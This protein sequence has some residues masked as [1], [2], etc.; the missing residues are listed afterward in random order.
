MSHPI[1]PILEVVI[2]LATRLHQTATVLRL[3]ATLRRLRATLRQLQATLR[4]LPATLRQ[5]LVTQRQPPQAM[6]TPMVTPDHT[7]GRL[8]HFYQLKW[9][10]VIIICTR[11]L[12]LQVKPV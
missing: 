9:H 12:T 3:P 7:K 11:K 6:V 8:V 2:H 1:L 4:Q 5:L 10:L